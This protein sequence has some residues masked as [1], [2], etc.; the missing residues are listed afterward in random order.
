MYVCVCVCVYMYV[1]VY[2]CVY[3]YAKRQ[4][5]K[6]TLITGPRLIFNCYKK[7]TLVTPK[8]YINTAGCSV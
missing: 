2:V 6:S 5:A 8:Q 3:V 4:A 1:C 7:E